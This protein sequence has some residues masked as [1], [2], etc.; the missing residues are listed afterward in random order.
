MS[1]WYYEASHVGTLD[2]PPFFAYFEYVLAQF[3][4]WCVPPDFMRIGA[5]PDDDSYLLTMRVSV[6]L[7]DFLFYYA[8]AKLTKQLGRS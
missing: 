2:Y 3:Q 1:Q 4:S 7:S 5:K 6:I 8:C